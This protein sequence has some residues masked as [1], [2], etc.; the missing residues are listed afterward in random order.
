MPK[1]FLVHGRFNIYPLF[2]SFFLFSSWGSRNRN[3]G[4]RINES[5]A[6]ENKGAGYESS[7]AKFKSKDSTSEHISKMLL[8]NSNMSPVS[9]PCI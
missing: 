2:L 8:S 9:S 7:D 3:D 6:A 4:R 1:E 5:A